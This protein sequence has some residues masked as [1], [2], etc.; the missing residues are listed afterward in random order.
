[1]VSFTPSIAPDGA[2]PSAS[3]EP[4][5]SVEPEDPALPNRQRRLETAHSNVESVAPSASFPADVPCR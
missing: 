1:M 4:P 3:A 2:L 5:L